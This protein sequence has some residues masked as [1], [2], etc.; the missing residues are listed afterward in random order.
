M[1]KKSANLKN[2][3]YPKSIAI[4]GASENENKVGGILVKKAIKSGVKVIPINPNHLQIFGLN[5]YKN[6]NDYKGKID[7]AIIAIPSL[8]VLGALNECGRNG[9]KNVIIISAGFSEIGN[10]KGELELVAT[11]K[12]YGI[13]F[14]G[15]NCFGICNPEK[16]L[17][18]TFAAVMPREGNIAFVSQ[19]GAL[20]SYVS[21]FVAETKNLGFS[22]FV[23]LGNMADLEFSDFID[24]FSKDKKTESIVLYVEKLKDGKKFIKSCKNCKK[25][26]YAIKA[27][28]SE[29]GSAA[30]FS[31]TASLASD[32]N[33]Y[34]GAFKQSGVVLCDSLIDAF[35]KASGR[36]LIKESGLGS[37]RIG[38][39][40]FILTN[41]GGAGALM[42][43]YL[44]KKGF[45]VVDKPWDIIGTASGSDY[46]NALEKLKEKDFYESIVAILTPQSMTE[47][48]KTA[49]VLAGF[50]QQAKKQVIALFLGGKS[51]K[52][53][54]K[55]FEEAGLPYFNTLEEARENLVF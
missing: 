35:E 54:N 33:I 30:A 28:S 16:N 5:C 15:T 27:G 7:L 45:S 14:L 9:I 52:E 53:A 21:D 41:A 13:K 8:F 6:I 12:K 20:W 46:F 3:F 25:P 19:S 40:V 47:I 17:D 31:H 55:I 48:K 37:I 26:I 38:R 10:V 39:K 44:S 32:Y 50:K 34:R 22:G 11:A 49:Q 24:Y 1:V 51:M 29:K 36:T 2:F 43:D 23:S 42:A 4:I 18:T